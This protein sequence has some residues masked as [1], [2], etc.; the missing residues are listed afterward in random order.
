M[1]AT[2]PGLSTPQKPKTFTGD[3]SQTGVTPYDPFAPPNAAAPTIPKTATGSA[4]VTDG[5]GT[6]ANFATWGDFNISPTLEDLYRQMAGQYTAQ[7]MTDQQYQNTSSAL[8]GPTA[9][10]GAYG[11]AQ[12]ALGGQ[13]ASQGY[14][15]ANQ[16]AY[17][18]PGAAE[19][20]G[21]Q[22]ASL[23]GQGTGNA[24]GAYTSAQGMV[25]GPNALDQHADAI[26]QG[27]NGATQIQDFAGR[28]GA[29][30]ET[31]GML[32]Q[33]AQQALTG[34]NPYYQQLSREGLAAVDQGNIARGAYAGTGGM[35]A[36]ARYQSNLDAQQYQQMQG[37]L[38]NAQSDQMQRLAQGGTLAGQASAETMAR[39]QSLEGLYNQQFQDKN[40]AANTL[41][42]GG[43]AADTSRLQT[44]AG[45]SNMATSA[46]T[47]ATNRLRA[48]A[49]A[50]SN[51][52]TSNVNQ[53]AT[54]GALANMADTSLNARMTTLGTQANQADTQRQNALNNLFGAAQNTQGAE[55]QRIN[56]ALLQQLGLS[57]AEANLIMSGYT[58]GNQISG[59]TATGAVNAGANA[60]GLIGQGQNADEAQRLQL[61]NLAVSA[62]GGGKR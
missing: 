22:A 46:E 50:A 37:L 2:P 28:Q 30:Y 42:Q 39:N 54:L 36:D 43:T 57:E 23:Y 52:D 45:M 41:I 32:E 48:G 61:L 31:P 56:S 14:Y 60:A 20:L 4:A 10:S 35:L 12:G 19:Q 26:G 17:S 13:S 58:S 8:S 40:T 25:G 7:G 33:F 34:T 62:Y 1:S 21:G 51:A 59:N 55:Q 24:Q 44:L 29:N 47:A 11:G 6:P 3:T 9:T 16:G 53:Q 18:A 38:Q 15:G 5:S 49:D 27:F